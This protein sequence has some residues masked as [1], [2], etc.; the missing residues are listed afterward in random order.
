MLYLVENYKVKNGN[1]EIGDVALDFV[2]TAPKV[3]FNK[4]LIVDTEVTLDCQEITEDERVALI[5]ESDIQKANDIPDSQR[6]SMIEA[7]LD[8]LILG[9][10]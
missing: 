8:E 2:E 7:A 9:G 5:E 3:L 10:A 1:I 4:K 6:L